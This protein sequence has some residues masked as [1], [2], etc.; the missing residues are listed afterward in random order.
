M[1]SSSI[2]PNP[3][4][5]RGLG[6]VFR[7]MQISDNIARYPEPGQPSGSLEFDRIKLTLAHYITITGQL[8]KKVEWLMLPWWKRLWLTIRRKRNV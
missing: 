5:K 6:V 1:A 3:A 7:G 8:E 2:R 4:D